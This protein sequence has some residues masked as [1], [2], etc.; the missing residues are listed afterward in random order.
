MALRIIQ[1][2]QGLTPDERGAA[3]AFGNFDGVHKGHQRVISEARIRAR[4][5][6]AP[7]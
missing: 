7:R 3:L 1:G 2:W 5:V 6:A 4:Q